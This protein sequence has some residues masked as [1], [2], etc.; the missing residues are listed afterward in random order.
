KE[1]AEDAQDI[2]VPVL[3]YAL[4]HFLDGQDALGLATAFERQGEPGPAMAQA[5]AGYLGRAVSCDPGHVLAGLSLALALNICGQRQAA[6]EQARRSL[7]RLE[8]ETTFQR[9]GLD[10]GAFPF[11]FDVFRVEWERCAWQHPGR[12]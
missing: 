4:Q 3:E 1:E 6:I 2:V 11:G 12:P 10:A 9:N 7:Q 8:C 5:A